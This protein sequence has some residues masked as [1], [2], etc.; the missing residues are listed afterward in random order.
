VLIAKHDLAHRHLAAQFEA[1][2]IQ[3]EYLAIVS[4]APDHDS[5]TIGRTIGF[6]PTNREKMAIRNP[7]DGGK[8]ALTFYQVIERFRG[9]AY[10]RCK[11]RTGRTHQIRVHLTH[12]GHPIVAD[13]LYSGRDR[14]SI[15]DLM[16]ARSPDETVLI[17]RQALHAH[18]LRLAH[19]LTDRPLEL[20]A[21][22]PPDMA[23]TLVA[24][25][26]HRLSPT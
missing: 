13:K 7:E 12:I 11:P 21:P 24:L 6:H 4:G 3:K 5:D 15:R 9:Y 2:T 16:G 8:E 14:L 10:I 18:T 1:R 26:E 17:E 25:R 19:P 23:K 22:L 20:V